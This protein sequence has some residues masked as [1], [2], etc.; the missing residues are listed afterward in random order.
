MLQFDS[1]AI[2]FKLPVDYLLDGHRFLLS[3]AN[4]MIA[5][6][7]VLVGLSSFFL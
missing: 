1:C 6:R 2:G 7:I 3:I 5:L 4:R